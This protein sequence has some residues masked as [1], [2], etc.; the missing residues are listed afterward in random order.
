MRS[1]HREARRFDPPLARKRQGSDGSEATHRWTLD[2][3]FREDQS[4][5]W[6][7][8]GAGNF[9]VLTHIALNPLRQEPSAKSLPRKRLVCA[10]NPDY[11]LKVLLGEKF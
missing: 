10:L 1:E 5:L 11:L 4:R 8:Y 3:N 9:A 2:V 7:G 6:T